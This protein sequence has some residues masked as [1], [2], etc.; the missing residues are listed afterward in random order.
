M[1]AASWEALGTSATVVVADERALE[2][3]R[4]A[5]EAELDAIDRACSRF[6]P[7]SELMQANR[8]A[9][10]PM[11]ISGL[12]TEALGV[13]LWAAEVTDGAVDPT[14][15]RALLSAGYDQ[16]DIARDLFISPKTVATH[17][18]RVLSKLGV[19]SRAQ[20]VAFFHA[21]DAQA[22]L[23]GADA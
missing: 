6:R 5:V 16:K 9:G 17:I 3:A 19:H 23:R 11:R 8:S 22:G 13:A 18:Q 20:A 2:P 7:D 1:S 10:Y 14:I 15:G 12:F 4:V 21:P